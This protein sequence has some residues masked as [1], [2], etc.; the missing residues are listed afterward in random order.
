MQFASLAVVTLPLTLPLILDLQVAGAAAVFE[1]AHLS[2]AGSAGCC[3]HGLGLP[4][5]CSRC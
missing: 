4:S 5:C 1:G 3:V 2:S